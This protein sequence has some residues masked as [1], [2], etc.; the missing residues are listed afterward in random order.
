MSIT[1]G[2]GTKVSDQQALVATDYTCSVDEDCPVCIG[3]GFE[4]EESE[5]LQELNSKRCIA[6]SCELSDACLIWDC[7]NAGECQSIKQTVLDN[8]V[9]RLNN[10]PIIFLL[11][12]GLII[13][14][15]MLK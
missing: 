2:E 8:T 13:A 6:G 3:A 11:I 1:P 14:F 7:G 9:G 12:V 4:V 15:I 10:N 5:F